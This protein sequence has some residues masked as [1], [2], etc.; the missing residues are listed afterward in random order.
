MELALEDFDFKLP[1][2]LI[3]QLPR[4]NRGEDRLM[5]VGRDS[6]SHSSMAGFFQKLQQ[7]DVVVINNSKVIKARLFGKRISGGRVEIMIDK[8]NSATEARVLLRSSKTLKIAEKIYLSTDV[9]VT[10]LAKKGQYYV[11]HSPI[12]WLQLCD[13]WGQLPLPPYIKREPIPS[14]DSRYQTVYASVPGSVAAPTAGLHFDLDFRDKIADAGAYLA[15]LTL[16][17]GSGTFAPIRS[18]KIADHKMHSESFVLTQQSCDIIN[19][20]RLRGGRVIAVGTTSL[21][22]LESIA[23]NA[24]GMFSPSVAETDIFIYPGY[25]F[26]MVDAL[27]TNFHLPKSTLLLLVS[28]Y[29]GR[30]RILNAY[31]EAVK[32]RYYFFSYGDAMFLDHSLY[33]A[34]FEKYK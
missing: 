10:I 23:C 13:S 28:A 12:S 20:C 21:R 2:N 32:E 16:N 8:I 7:N 19:R 9:A 33:L 34:S 18:T 5:V 27:L 31:K 30:K 15:E 14:I 17:I 3:A 25:K 1:E 11:L 29:A 4:D 6:V 24:D 22:V 26:K